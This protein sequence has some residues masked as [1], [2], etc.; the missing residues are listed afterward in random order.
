MTMNTVELSQVLPWPGKLGF[1]KTRARHLAAAE[2]LEADEAER[3]LTVRVVTAYVEI[4]ALDRTVTV[5]ERTRELLRSFLDV[6]RSMYAVGS[7]PQQDVL[8]AQVAIARMSEDL[9]VLGAGRPP[10]RLAGS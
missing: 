3:M 1:G 8:Q 4:A 6:A 7:A 9:L 5:M 2:A 10:Q